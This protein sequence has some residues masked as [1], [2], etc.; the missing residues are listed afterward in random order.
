[1]L[2]VYSVQRRIFNGT[3]EHAWR[4]RLAQPVAI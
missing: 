4:D 1:M 2:S 3:P